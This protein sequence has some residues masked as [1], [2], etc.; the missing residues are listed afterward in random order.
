MKQLGI[1]NFRLVDSSSVRG[2]SLFNKPKQVFDELRES[3][4]ETVIDFRIEGSSESKYARKCEANGLEYFNFKI[5]EN[6]SMFNP[7]GTS[8]ESFEEFR[9]NREVFVK[10]LDKFFKLMER[11]RVYMACL[12]GLHRT[13]LAVSL[14]YLLNPKEPQTP[15]SLSHM[16]HKNEQNMTN[17]RIGSVK[18][19]V[20]NLSEDNRVF[21]GL[22]VDL[23]AIFSERIAK[24]RMMNLL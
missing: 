11:G 2:Q 9:A 15:P 20:K 3:G 18:N 10:D 14:N 1:K 19:L 23:T 21:L 17:K 16:F 5:K 13:D 22:P 7:R 4:I 12:L 24:L 8:K 6:M